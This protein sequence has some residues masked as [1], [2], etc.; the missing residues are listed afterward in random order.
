MKL[1]FIFSSL[2]LLVSTF[3]GE[4][5]YGMCNIWFFVFLLF[6]FSMSSVLFV[7]ILF[8]LGLDLQLFMLFDLS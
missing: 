8:F 1:F 4:S 6:Y 5:V 3:L 2:L 7:N